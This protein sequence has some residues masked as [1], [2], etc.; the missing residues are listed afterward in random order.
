[1]HCT[2]Y[3]WRKKYQFHIQDSTLS[4]KS[5]IGRT[6][7]IA[8][9]TTSVLSMDEGTY[10]DTHTYVHMTLQIVSVYQYDTAPHL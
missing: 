9:G 1:M 10:P 6:Q 7:A 5:C 4:N 3:F 8:N 2:V